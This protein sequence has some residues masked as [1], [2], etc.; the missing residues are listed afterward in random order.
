MDISTV[1][2]FI[3]C[4][5]CILLSIFMMEG[6]SLK[7][8][9][10]LPGMIITF[11]G[12]FAVVLVGFP[13][14]RV[15]RTIKIVF[16]AF[17]DKPINTLDT[18]YQLIEFSESARR[19][20]ILSLEPQLPEVKDPFV[21]AGL[22]L[23]IDGVEPA[24]IEDILNTDIAILEDRHAKGAAVFSYMAMVAPAIGMMGTI[25]ALITVLKNL[26]E[27]SSIGPSMAVALCTTLYGVFMAYT[28]LNPLASKLKTKSQEEVIHKKMVIEGIMSIQAGDNPRILE[29]K[30]MVFLPPEMRKSKYEAA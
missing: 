23:V 17:S 5:G 21:R 1:V 30:L 29:Q 28:I 11:G 2:G 18:I 3:F 13:L 25:L 4:Y 22:S 15:L 16:Q 27:P 20:G 19:S 6:S 12:V 24:L 10:D 26:D 14:P 9:I 7:T 8:Y